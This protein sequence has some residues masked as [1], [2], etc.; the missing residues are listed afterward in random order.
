MLNLFK[1]PFDGIQSPVTYDYQTCLYQNESQEENSLTQPLPEESNNRSYFLDLSNLNPFQVDEIESHRHAHPAHRRKVIKT[2]DPRLCLQA[3]PEVDE[4]GKVSLQ[5][6]LKHA[7]S[8][9][10]LFAKTAICM[11]N[12][13]LRSDPEKVRD[14]KISIGRAY[15]QLGK[16]SNGNHAAHDNAGAGVKDTARSCM[17]EEI[18][19]EKVI[20]PMKAEL[21]KYKGFTAQDFEEINASDFNPKKI[22]EVFNRY[23]PNEAWR[24]SSILEGSIGEH[25]VNQTTIL[26]RRINLGCDRRLEKIA[27]PI[28]V[29]LYKAV[30]VGALQPEEA[31]QKYQEVLLKHLQ[32]AQVDIQYRLSAIKAYKAALESLLKLPS[33]ED[34]TA[35]YVTLS[36]MSLDHQPFSSHKVGRVYLHSHDKLLEI[37]KRKIALPANRPVLENMLKRTIFL[38]Q[39]EVRNEEVKF[40]DHLEHCRIQEEGTRQMDVNAFFDSI[41]DRP[42]DQDGLADVRKML[43]FDSFHD[44]KTA[45]FAPLQPRALDLMDLD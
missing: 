33:Y 15:L 14:L 26:K 19:Q 17:I 28:M 43:D 13:A 41:K 31:T 20:T 8:R 21:L 18:H 7:R 5:N 25:D 30:S 23:W 42:Y 38:L 37:V 39:W 3:N 36:D 22:E 2:D 29:E 32:G 34:L 11:Q 27:R 10:E 9:V 16:G 6:H 24:P 35:A 45:M 12:T 40:Q 1:N 44:I 4:N